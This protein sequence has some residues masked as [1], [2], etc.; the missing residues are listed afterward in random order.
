M[1]KFIEFIQKR[2]KDTTIRLGRIGFG[3]VLALILGLNLDTI[4]LNLPVWLKMYETGILYGLFIFAVMPIF[5]GASN[6]CLLK[7]KHI[8]I[9]QTC[10]GILLMFLGNSLIDT[11]WVTQ[12]D[13]IITSQSGSLDYG[14]ITEVSSAKKPVNVGF[15]IALLGIIPLLCWISGKCI[16]S[17]CLKHGEVIKKIRV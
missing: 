5:M 3:S 1:F 2:P 17:T 16:T 13:P 15:W 10:F 12:I 6:V 8:R 9:I 7:R 14:N 4:V 11:K